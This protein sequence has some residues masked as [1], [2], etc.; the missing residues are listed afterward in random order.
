M[1]FRQLFITGSVII[2]LKC[3]ICKLIFKKIDASF[4]LITVAYLNLLQAIGWQLV[5][6]KS[7]KIFELLTTTFRSLIQVQM[8]GWEA[9][10]DWSQNSCTEMSNGPIFNDTQYS[11]NVLCWNEFIRRA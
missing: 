5:G 7:T 4:T 10:R 2:L 3:K 8:V 11:S 1:R 9:E 6:Q